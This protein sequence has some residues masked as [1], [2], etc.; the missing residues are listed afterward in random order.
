[1]PGMRA[2][3]DDVLAFAFQGRKFG[4]EPVLLLY[5]YQ[6]ELER[7]Q[8]AFP[9]VVAFGEAD[10]PRRQAELIAQWSAG[11]IGVLAGARLVAHRHIA[12]G[13]DSPGWRV[14]KVFTG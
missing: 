5:Q 11:T 9:Y 14:L 1:M 12:E 13:S 4:R 10:T 3:I 6:H 7:I 2:P 8:A